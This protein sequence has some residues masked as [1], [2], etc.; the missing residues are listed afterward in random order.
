MN[1]KVILTCTFAKL[2]KVAI[3]SLFVLAPQFSSL[4]ALATS[5]T[6]LATT[7]ANGHVLSA[8]RVNADPGAPRH[9]AVLPINFVENQGQWDSEVLFQAKAAPYSVAVERN[10]FVLMGMAEGGVKRVRVAFSG[11]NH[12]T[13]TIGLK[14]HPGRHNFYHGDSQHLGV[15]GYEE[16]QFDDIYPG[17]DARLY[18]K[19]A[20]DA[21]YL[22]YDIIVE[23]YA[24]LTPL[25]LVTEGV[26]AVRLGP[27]GSLIMDT[28]LGEISQPRPVAWYELPQGGRLSAEVQ[29]QIES[30]NAFGFEVRNRRSDL[31]L[32]IDPGLLI[33][34][35]IGGTLED[36]LED[37][38]QDPVSGDYFIAISEILSQD[39]DV[40]VYRVNSDLTQIVYTTTLSGSDN[41]RVLSLK[42]G[43][44]V[45]NVYLAGTSA[46]TN[47]PTS[48]GA[49]QANVSGSRS[50]ILSVLGMNS[51]T[52]NYST[53]FG[54]STICNGVD[55]DAQG[56]AHLAMDLS[57]SGSIPIAP[58]TTPYQANN[59]GPGSISTWAYAQI[60]PVGGG[61]SDLL[62]ST[63]FGS[64]GRDNVWAI[65]LLDSSGQRIAFAGATGSDLYPVTP[66]A[67]R[68]V[69][70]GMSVEAFVT[71][72]SL[73]TPAT[74]TLE[75]STFF[76]A[77]GTDRAKD[78]D[79]L[80]TPLGKS[81]EM[82]VF[83]GTSRGPDFPATPDAVQSVNAGSD[84]AFV[85][86]LIPAGTGANDLVYATLVGGSSVEDC[87]HLELDPDYFG[88]VG[89]VGK[90]RSADFPT[91]RGALQTAL[92]SSYD[93]FYSKV[94]AGTSSTEL[95]YS[96]YLGASLDDEARA[97]VY[98]DGDPKEVS[99]AGFTESND[100]YTTAGVVG[101][102]YTGGAT[103]GFVTVLS[104]HT[105]EPTT[106]FQILQGSQTGGNLVSL[107]AVD[108][109]ALE[110]L[111]SLLIPG[112]GL[113]IYWTE[114]SFVTN[115]AVQALHELGFD[116]HLE[117]GS[118]D[119]YSVEY[120]LVNQVSGVSVTF[121]PFAVAGGQPY[122][123]SIAT[124]DPNDL[125][126][127]APNHEVEVKVRVY[128]F[129]PNHPAP[130]VPTVKFEQMLYRVIE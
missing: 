61:Q 48:V 18:E 106:S 63:Y 12:Q 117:L 83:A 13:Q 33:S 119:A 42:L 129:V 72:L 109:D 89:I 1:I 115:L 52:I 87:V 125:V 78:I 55:V 28:V 118:L 58:G 95:S 60:N 11:A 86:M 43:S 57:G 73:P 4:P 97:F 21:R 51:G 96:S 127:A 80:E 68:T 93:G 16:V 53:Y 29:F 9:L 3:L 20:Q 100:Y 15:V 32:V 108:Q 110:V 30:G 45:G 105:E 46:S 126:G 27:D 59:P 103:D 99:I 124:D 31:R 92:A 85:A 116:L 120:D 40:V 38:T 65:R 81:S 71:V 37:M 102:T 10:A 62:H 79:Y 14:A 121:G 6:A 49:F 64:P 128:A 34:S 130:I 25:R 88:R 54:T 111:P 122:T 66:G 94:V 26:R 2:L 19:R 17:I 5:A 77:R 123:L 67:H 24:P 69:R 98:H 70:I 47:Y 39:G 84:D 36:K 107:E 8:D 82:I 101:P 7:L 50:C 44:S 76:G 35:Y 90:S 104:P 112:Q 22:E 114:T 41:D 56:R 74:S 23:P 113:D 75:Y 91:T